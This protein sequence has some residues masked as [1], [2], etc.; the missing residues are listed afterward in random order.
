MALFVGQPALLT[1]WTSPMSFCY[2]SRGR[3]QRPKQGI[4][5]QTSSE[6]ALPWHSK[7][8]RLKPKKSRTFVVTVAPPCLC[9]TAG[10]DEM[11]ARGLASHLRGQR[12]GHSTTSCSAA[13]GPYEGPG[14]SL[15]AASAFGGGGATKEVRSKVRRSVATSRFGAAAAIGT[16]GA[17]PE[18]ALQISSQAS[19]PCQGSLGAARARQQRLR[20]RDILADDDDDDDDEDDDEAEE[21]E[22]DDGGEDDDDVDAD[23]DDDDDD[24]GDEDDEDDEDDDDDDDDH[25]DD[26]DDDDDGE[27]EGE[28]EGEHD[29][30]DD[31]DDDD[32]DDE[33]GHDGRS[34]ANCVVGTATL[35][36]AAKSRMQKEPPISGAPSMPARETEEPRIDI[37]PNVIGALR[38]QAVDLEARREVS[39]PP[40]GLPVPRAI[41]LTQLQWYCNWVSI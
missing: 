13:N 29:D 20:G 28:G 38:P 14:P 19:G 39:A 15:S 32:D 31:Y 36:E 17:Q 8:C 35:L 30:G 5:W 1:G 37:M 4:Q 33:R 6:E 18:T 12:F 34:G 40:E 24:D 41:A 21:E 3:P 23:V 10:A 26:D 22:E 16:Q 25:D 27:G 11:H 9:T 7:A 2:G